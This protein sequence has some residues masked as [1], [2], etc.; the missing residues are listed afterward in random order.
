MN[1]FSTLKVLI[2]DDASIVVVTIKGMLLRL[3]FSDRLITYCSSAR[4]A[5]QLA[6]QEQYDLILCDYNLGRG[7]NGKQVFEEMKHYNLLGEK[8]VLI[9]ITGESS[10]TVVH[11]IIELKPDDYLLKPFTIILLRERI[12]SAITRKFALYQL[13]NVQLNHQYQEGVSLCDDLLPFYPEYQFTIARFKGEFLSRLQLHDQS[14]SLYEY[15]LIRK[16]CD[17]ATIGL[18]NSLMNLG[19][20]KSAQTMIN[21]L[22]STKPNSTL[23]RT[24]AAN[25][26]LMSNA[27]PEAIRHFKLASKLVRGNSEREMVIANLCL[28]V[29]DYQ[30][31]LDR[32]RAYM[33]INKDTYRNTIFAKINLIRFILYSCFN[34]EP[35]L[36]V[37]RLN[38]AKKLYSQVTSIRESEK[39]KSELDLLLAHI[40]LEEKQYAFAISKLNDIHRQMSFNHFY[41]LHQFAWILNRMNFDSEFAR[42][43]PKCTEVIHSDQNEHILSSQ[44]TMLKQIQQ[45]NV[46]K[47]EWLESKHKYIQANRMTLNE[48]LKI[49]IEINQ[50]CPFLQSVCM[51]IIKLLARRWPKDAD[52]QFIM[53]IV[54]Q[55]DIMIRQLMNDDEQEKNNYEQLYHKI[56]AIK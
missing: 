38:E 50:R 39:L 37:A 41:P 43:I 36:K 17:W 6:R 8:S 35:S 12:H 23:V 42:L 10:A 48:L 4:A 32:Y 9:L 47:L 31:A 53:G 24:A 49:Y 45:T 34:A 44:M 33:E 16:E 56:L 3:G 46:D 7:I 26:S 40:A 21:K 13:Y 20:K 55:C 18:A 14:K 28:S 25:I 22:L 54:Q 11:S 1:Q 29:G 52:Y 27:V 30:S 19:D 2:I 5:M 51:S 15:V